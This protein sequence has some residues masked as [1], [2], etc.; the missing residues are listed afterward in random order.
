MTA[1]PNI[2]P[3]QTVTVTE[4]IKAALTS[5]VLVPTSAVFL[6][7]YG[8]RAEVREAIES[9][10]I[11]H[12]QGGNKAV[13]T[14]W[15]DHIARVVPDIAAIVDRPKLIFHIS[16]LESRPPVR[17]LIEGEVPERALTVIFGAP[18]AGKSFLA[19]DYGG[20]IAREKP[21]VYIAGEGGSGYFARYKAWL[22]HNGHKKTGQFHIVDRPIQMLNAN[23][24]AWF[25]EEARAIR[26]AVV[27]IDTLSRC[28]VGG[29][30][31]QQKDMGL[32]IAACDQIRLELDCAVIIVHHTGKAGD[33]ERGSSVLRGAADSMIQVSNA[34]GLIKI[35]SSKT[36][37]GKHFLT[38]YCR[39]MEVAIEQNGEKLTSCVLEAWN[40]VKTDPNELT[41][42]QFRILE[43]LASE[44]FSEGVKAPDL[45][46]ACNVQG[47][48][49]YTAL[50]SLVKRGFAKKI[51]RGARLDPIIITPTGMAAVRK[52]VNSSPLGGME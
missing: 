15:K 50:N 39:R 48:S 49:F 12:K 33:N 1:A 25:I 7:G 52:S 31:N 17:W 6:N 36:K 26:P 30:E 46:A 37:D 44:L 16:E 27:I 29:D 20:Q 4:W 11:V 8:E 32:F 34:E 3:A 51:G 21:I 43:S 9:I 38:R 10:A 42:N 24:V 35:E 22:N 13:A 28:M 14:A 2:L 47:S 5:D 45:K 41:P 19:V 18:E 23:Q 40:R